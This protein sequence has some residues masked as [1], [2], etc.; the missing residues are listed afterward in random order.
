MCC[1][2][3][4]ACMHEMFRFKQNFRPKLSSAAIQMTKQSELLPFWSNSTNWS[5]TTLRPWRLLAM[6]ITRMISPASIFSRNFHIAN[7]SPRIWSTAITKAQIHWFR[8]TS[9]AQRN[10]ILTFTSILNETSTIVTLHAKYIYVDLLAKMSRNGFLAPFL[11]RRRKNCLPRKYC[12]ATV[13]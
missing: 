3:L 7:I 6:H 4:G 1:G 8:Y 10:A 9:H 11:P 12:I 5:A 2:L 13:R